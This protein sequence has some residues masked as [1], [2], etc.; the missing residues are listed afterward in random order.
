MTLKPEALAQLH[1]DCFQSSRPWSVDEFHTL[2]DDNNVLLIGDQRGF[3]LG[4]VIL[5]E[6]ELLSL[7]VSPDHRRQGTARS[8]VAKFEAAAI[9]RG[10]RT[11]FLEVDATNRPAI[12]LYLGQGYRESGRRKGYYTHKNAPAS[13]AMLMSKAL[14]AA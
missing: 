5:D 3:I 9:Q 4:R 12:A 10:A 2:L 8:L 6:V 7:A 1:R 14:K 11:C 13:D